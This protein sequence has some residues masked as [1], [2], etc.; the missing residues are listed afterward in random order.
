MMIYTIPGKNQGSTNLS[1]S[2]TLYLLYI[3]CYGW[4][5]MFATETPRQAVS[6]RQFRCIRFFHQCPI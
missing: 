1:I 5:M 3:R 4:M 2:T 6:D